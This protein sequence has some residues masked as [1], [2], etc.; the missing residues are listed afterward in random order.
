MTI[1][2]MILLLFITGQ[3]GMKLGIPFLFLAPEYF[4]LVNFWSFFFLG[5][6]FGAFY[7]SWNLTI[8]LLSAHLF[9]F[10]ASLAK[11]FTKFSINNALLPLG[12]I[13]I[14]LGM[15]VYFQAYYEAAGFWK[16]AGNVLGFLAGM[17]SLILSYTIYF[18]F[19]NRDISYYRKREERPPNL[20]HSI[21][22]GHRG[23]DLDY[24]KQD[25]QAWKVKTYINE[26]LRIRIV[27]SVAHYDSSMLMSIFKQNHL[28]AL[29]TQLLTMMALL[30]LGYLIDQPAFRIPAAASVFILANV[31]T[32]FIGAITYWFNTWRTTIIILL[33]I[34]I[35]FFTGF[36][37]FNRKNKAYGLD[38]TSPPAVYAVDSMVALTQTPKIEQDI[39]ETTAI[40][41]RWKAKVQK[42]SLHKPKMI[43]FAVSGGGLKSALWAMQVVRT[44]DQQLNGKLLDHT[45]LITGASGGMMG[46][47]FLRELYL[48]QQQGADLSI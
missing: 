5:L 11:P 14:Y 45:V 48:R 32:A 24:I 38:Y 21:A 37:L 17:V 25:H 36:E 10:L 28:N 6:A 16:I 33:L 31:F 47:A 30:L 42:D 12:F 43:L 29:I 40:L 4:E 34:A 8:Y 41:D 20:T 1:I 18:Q 15:I 26:F 39:Q 2:W 35:N 44:A 7:M 27:R 9:P 3:F 13:L 22:P 23:V 46:M 19:T